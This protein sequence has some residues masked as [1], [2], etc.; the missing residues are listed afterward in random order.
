MLMAGCPRDFTIV[1]ELRLRKLGGLE[2]V[3]V[4]LHV[5]ISVICHSH[6]E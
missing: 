5:I 3:G 1:E 2:I 6:T 4:F